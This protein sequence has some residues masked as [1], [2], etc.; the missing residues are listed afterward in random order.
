MLPEGTVNQIKMLH[1]D[2]ITLRQIQ[3]ILTVIG[4]DLFSKMQIQSFLFPEKGCQFT[5]ESEEIIGRMKDH[6]DYTEELNAQ[7]E[8]G[9]TRLAVLTCMNMER[10]FHRWYISQYQMGNFSNNSY[11]QML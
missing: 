1:E 6:D 5:V 9:I 8:D 3:M 4:E 11:P 7:S 10:D 2:G